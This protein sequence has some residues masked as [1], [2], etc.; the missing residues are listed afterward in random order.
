MDFAVIS[1][2]LIEWTVNMGNLNLVS[3]ESLSSVFVPA[4]CLPIGDLRE[5][6]LRES[7]VAK[8]SLLN[9]L[10]QRLLPFNS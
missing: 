8:V 9:H 7:V 4:S 2:L 10:K 6:I 3:V 5:R 1:S